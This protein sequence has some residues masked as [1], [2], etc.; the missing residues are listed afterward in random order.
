MKIR[1]R[2]EDIVEGLRDWIKSGLKE[3]PRQGYDLGKFFFSVSVGTIGALV[4]IEKLNTLPQMDC[5]MLLALCLLFFSVVIA[6]LLALP[7]TY[8]VRGETD[9]LTEYNE[10]IKRIIIYVWV[11][12]FLWLIGAIIGG[13][14][15]RS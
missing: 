12:F 9:L 1:L 11:W 4:A 14:A 5:L 2:G 13:F 8:R 10:Q 7:R 6:L 3:G 15:I